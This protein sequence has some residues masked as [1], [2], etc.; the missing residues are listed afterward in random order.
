[1]ARMIS[2]AKHLLAIFVTAVLLAACSGGSAPIDTSIVGAGDNWGNPSGDWSKSRFSRLTDISADNVGELGMAWEYD[3]GTNRVQEA[4]PVVIDGVMYASGNLG[5]VYALN[6]ATGEELWTFTPEVNMQVNR[7][8]CCDQANRGLAVVDDKVIVGALDGWLYALDTKTG[9]EVWKANTIADG[10]RSHTI[11]GAPEIA[12]E[13]VIIGNGGA[14]YDGRGYVTAYHIS[15][16]K[17]AWRFWIVPHDPADGPQES[18]ALEK[19]LETWDPK[20]RW[21]VGGGG[22]AWDAITYDP[23]FDQVIVGTGKGGPY[24]A[25]IRSPAGGDN[26]YLDSLVALDPKTGELKWYFQETPQDSWD[27][28]A[29]Q[30]M[31]LTELEVNGQ[32]RPV[33]LHAPKN[34]FMF[35]IDRETGKPLSINALVRTSWASG[36]NMETGKPVLTPEYSEY[37]TGPKIVFPASPGARNWFPAAWDPDR[38]LYFGN[39]QDMGNLMFLTLAP[40][41]R[42]THRQQALNTGSALL[43][44]ADLPEL[45]KTL[46]PPV[47]EEIMALPQWKWVQEMPYSNQLRAI[48]PLTGKT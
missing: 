13:M 18:E 39:V 38:K 44:T 45:A 48:D 33:I 36:W 9:K 1:M 3:L 12:G 10:K 46:P 32:Q 19:A 23:V 6:A 47:Q 14:D 31:V 40:G 2:P 16:G 8:A 21:D 28:T 41:E 24:P 17:E 37:S 22:H 35:V 43:F 27:L 34:G 7:Y 25:K 42:L 26:L 5:R 11:T 20:S 4:T 29:V 30:P 15:D